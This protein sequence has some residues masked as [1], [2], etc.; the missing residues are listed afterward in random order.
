MMG[1]KLI[2]WLAVY[3]STPPLLDKQLGC[4]CR[5]RRGRWWERLVVDGVG[6]VEVVGVGYVGEERL[7]Y[8]AIRHI[9]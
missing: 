3:F 8:V 5:D 9:G 1:W 7:M 4:L 6:W 2:R